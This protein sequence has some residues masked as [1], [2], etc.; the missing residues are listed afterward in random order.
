MTK[1][2]S[3]ILIAGVGLVLSV[4]PAA[5]GANGIHGEVLT[6]SKTNAIKSGEKIVVTGAHFDE[7]VGIYV[8]MCLLVKKGVKPTPCGGGADKTGATAASAWISS[9]PPTY[10]IGLAK[11]YLP[12][13]RFSVNLKVSPMIGKLD[14][15]K[16]KCAVYVRAD[17]IEGDVRTYDIAVPIAFHK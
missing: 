10:G 15:R 5:F 13:G 9:N 16:L 1:R 7:T 14:C 6:V 2:I 17:H 11:P 3:L 8:A 12:G 4:V